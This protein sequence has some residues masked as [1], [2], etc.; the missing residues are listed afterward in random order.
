MNPGAKMNWLKQLWGR[1]NLDALLNELSP[2]HPG[3]SYQAVDRYRDYRAVF[4]ESN[5]GRRVLWDILIMCRLYKSSM[6]QDSH[7]TAF[8][9][10]KREIGLRILGTMNAEPSELQQEATKDAGP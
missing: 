6:N 5:R 10:G 2:H 9:E 1:P 7:V 3:E 8:N 4:L